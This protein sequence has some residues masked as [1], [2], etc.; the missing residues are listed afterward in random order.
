MAACHTSLT[1]DE[2]ISKQANPGKL[3]HSSIELCQYLIPAKGKETFFGHEHRA[4]PDSEEIFP[5][6]SINTEVEEEE[7]EEST[8]CITKVK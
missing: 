1:E 6:Y 4:P 8:T 5:A 3:S 7:E 2:A